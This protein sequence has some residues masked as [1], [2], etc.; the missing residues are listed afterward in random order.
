MNEGGWEKV[1]IR[2]QFASLE[3]DL[4]WYGSQKI[5]RASRS[6]LI[7]APPPTLKPAPG[8]PRARG[9]PQQKKAEANDDLER[10]TI[11]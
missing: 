7:P 2:F 6:Q 5:P 3:A 11:A 4:T 9:G 8:P 10:Q 1:S